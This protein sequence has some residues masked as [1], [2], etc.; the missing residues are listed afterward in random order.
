[1]IVNCTG[2]D[3]RTDFAA[4]ITKLEN[5]TGHNL[6]LVAQ[7]EDQVC[8]AIWGTGNADISGIGVS[9]ETMEYE[10]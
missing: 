7:C 5:A 3:V 9:H 4:Y 2:L 10:T 6:S 1:M 8:T